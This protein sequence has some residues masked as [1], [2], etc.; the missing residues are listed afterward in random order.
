[1]FAEVKAMIEDNKIKLATTEQTIKDHGLVIT[2]EH[3][4]F[5]DLKARSDEFLIQNGLIL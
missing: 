1:M 5:A 3:T 4:K 2:E